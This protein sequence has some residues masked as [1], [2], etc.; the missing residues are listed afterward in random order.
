M[1]RVV[2]VGGEAR[3]PGIVVET[4]EKKITENSTEVKTIVCSFSPIWRKVKRLH[5]ERLP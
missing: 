2:R 5:V 1:A 3:E 4:Q